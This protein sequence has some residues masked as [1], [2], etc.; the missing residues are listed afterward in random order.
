M[1]KIF[2]LGLFGL[3]FL[4]GC[5]KFDI[6][7]AKD[8]FKNKVNSAKAYELKGNMEIY[9]NED[10]FKYD[11]TVN[12]KKNDLYK[13]SMI[14]KNNNHEQI[15]LKNEDSVYVVTP[16]L[17]KSFKFES[18]WPDNSSQSYIL[19]SLLNDV[20]NDQEAKLMEKDGKYVITCK[21]NYPHNKSLIKQELYFNKDMDLEKVL[22]YDNSQNIK[23]KVNVKNLDYKAKYKDNYFDLN[24][25]IDEDVT[26]D[27]KE[28]TGLLEDAIYPLYIP[29]NTFLQSK[30][31]VTDEQTDRTILTFKGDKSFILVEEVATASK[32]FE[33]IPVNGD[34]LLLTDSIA[35]LSDNSL[36]WTSN[37]IDYYLTSAKLSTDE[38]MT[39]AQS[40]GNV[41]LEK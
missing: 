19:S 4:C 18:T 20:L 30:D 21:V 16:S 29:N 37:N 33:V 38:L 13:V 15:I 31:K 8:E 3:L 40:M 27:E 11:I 1:K 25:L 9:N 35:A 34:P 10:T 23:I 2:I 5:G 26:D 39:I 28:E 6:E 41:A 24:T 7:K 22:V 14:N 32:E 12:Y 36:T 17:N